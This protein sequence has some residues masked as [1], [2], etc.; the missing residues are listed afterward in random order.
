MHFL[1]LSRRVRAGTERVPQRQE[2]ILGAFLH[3]IIHGVSKERLEVVLLEVR[4]DFSPLILLISHG[5]TQTPSHA[6]TSRLGLRFGWTKDL[7]ATHR[8]DRGKIG[9]PPRIRLLRNT[10]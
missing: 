6:K 3:D 8:Q 10:F 7:T 1:D 5:R 4:L 2:W 9:N